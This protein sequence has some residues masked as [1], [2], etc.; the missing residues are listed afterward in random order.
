MSSTFA[1]AAGAAAGTEAGSGAAGLV[2][3]AGGAG[4]ASL[5]AGTGAGAV[6]GA[7]SAGA[8]SVGLV[9]DEDASVVAVGAASLA[10]FSFF[11]PKRFLKTVFTLSAASRAVVGG[12][13]YLLDSTAKVREEIVLKSTH[14]RQAC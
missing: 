4:T 6:A 5:L 3:F 1:G 12:I 7:G 2:S 9:V 14:G 11:L 13:R 8:V 10:F